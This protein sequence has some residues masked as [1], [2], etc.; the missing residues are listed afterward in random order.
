MM[1]FIRVLSPGTRSF[2]LLGPR[3]TGKSTW[4]KQVFSDAFCI[5]LLN[6]KDYYRLSAQPGLFSEMVL[7]QKKSTWI[8]VDEVQRLAEILNEVHAL[9]ENHGYRFVLTGSSARKLKAGKANLLAGR[10]VVKHFFPLVYPEWKEHCSFSEV[11]EWGCM[12]GVLNSEQS[13]RI[14]ILE[15]YTGTYLRE[16]IKE[17]ALI[18]NV[19]HFSRFFHV[20]ALSH[21]Q[22]T[23]FSNI[24]RDAAVS[25]SSVSGYYAILVDT[26]IGR[27]LPAWQPKKRVKEVQH[28][29]FYFFDTGVVR[30]LQGLLRDPLSSEIKGIYLETYLLHEL[31]AY[32]SIKGIGGEFFYWRTAD[33]VEVDVVWVRA[34][35]A[36]AIEVKSSSYWK[37]SFDH[38]LKA[39]DLPRSWGVYQGSEILKKPW[40][41]V[42]PV[43]QFLEKLW[44]GEILF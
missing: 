30:S 38:G 13:Q 42:L 22:I 39:L 12:P 11:L 28:P 5:D 37:S 40:G 29:K 41:F 18:R 36:V 8:V 23:S 10:A 24:S 15:A 43:Q 25:R 7:A 19:P 31:T 27:F 26:L 44:L 33:Q 21:G 20:A 34:E 6:T 14:E 4:L 35:H 32:Q 16:E 1:T 2:F 17:E 3:A 9:I